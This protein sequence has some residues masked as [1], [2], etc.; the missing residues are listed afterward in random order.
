MELVFS[1]NTLKCEVV[2]SIPSMSI[3]SISSTE[4]TSYLLDSNGQIFFCSRVTP[5]SQFQL[6]FVVTSLS[7]GREHI[8]A[9]TE[10]LEVFTWGKGDSGALGLGNT[11]SYSL[12]QKINL[13]SD[14]TITQVACGAWHTVFISHYQTNNNFLLV[15]GRNSEGQLGTGK[16]CRELLPC[17][18]NLPEEICKVA[19]GTNHTIALV[20]SK[21][22]YSTGDNHFGQ[23]GLGNKRSSAN[24]IRVDIEGV[25]DVACGHHSAAVK[26]SKCFVWGTGGFGE[27]LIPKELTGPNFIK[28]VC[29]GDGIGCA[30]DAN[31]KIWTWGGKNLGKTMELREENIKNIN[32]DSGVVVYS[33]GQSMRNSQKSDGRFKSF[34][35]SPKCMSLKEIAFKEKIMENSIGRKKEIR[36]S[37]EKELELEKRV[38]EIEIIADKEIEILAE[39]DKEMCRMKK[40]VDDVMRENKKVVED[41][42]KLFE[43]REKLRE[44]VEKLSVE[45]KRLQESL[46]SDCE[47]KDIYENLLNELEN[48][49]KAN[50]EKLKSEIKILQYENDSAQDLLVKLREEN[51]E[52]SQQFLESQQSSSILQD[53][54]QQSEQ[55][56]HNLHLK[57]QV[58]QEQLSDLTSANQNLYKTIEKTSQFHQS[59]PILPKNP[60]ESPNFDLEELQNTNR[61]G[62]SL[63]QQKRLLELAA[64]NVKIDEPGFTTTS[65]L[66]SKQK[67]KPDN[68]EVHH[69]VKDLKKIEIRFK[70]ICK[71]LKEDLVNK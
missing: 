18:V 8:C 31:G 21:S 32:M 65:P 15:M 53:K 69:K 46:R 63:N 71:S 50:I 66:K 57:I 35:S 27:A 44:I 60:I 29:V 68:F 42:E 28:K 43:D 25:D 40:Y 56:S 3:K 38:R 36:K 64:R 39:K 23:L 26:N 4:K 37:E 54:I 67:K 19:C 22:L 1:D 45:N 30:F 61:K 59:L 10:N 2:Q 34:M 70:A 49:S 51:F 47:I 33:R 11:I 52:L 41:N 48:K 16:L 55:I 24:F 20:Q 9:L 5:L 13:S 17:R 6:P 12:P 14:H 7:C 58:L 62:L